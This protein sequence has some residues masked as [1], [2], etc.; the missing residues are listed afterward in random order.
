MILSTSTA[1]NM[2]TLTI[3]NLAN[4]FLAFFGSFLWN[5][6][7]FQKAKDKVDATNLDFP[8]KD[9]LKKNW[10]NWFI[11]TMVAPVLVWFLPDIIATLNSSFG[12]SIVLYKLYYLGAGVLVE[13]M[14]VGFA[15][16]MKWKAK[17]F[18]EVHE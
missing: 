2:K 3:L 10:D 7:V 13:V 4:Y 11:T 1:I 17:F 15:V 18:P 6:F 14:Y 9:Y 8:Y 12:S 16:L 5:F